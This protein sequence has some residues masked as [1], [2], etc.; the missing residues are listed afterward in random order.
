[1][2]Y[3]FRCHIPLPVV[4]RPYVTDRVPSNAGAVYGGH[5]T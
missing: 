5:G 2:E 1:M 3:C 4:N